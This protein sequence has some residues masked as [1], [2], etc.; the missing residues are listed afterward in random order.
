M[1][2]RHCFI[3]T[4]FLVLRCC[5]VSGLLSIKSMR[6]RIIYLNIFELSEQKQ[7]SNK[8]VYACVCVYGG[9]M[10]LHCGPFIYSTK[11][12]YNNIIWCFLLL[13]QKGRERELFHRTT[14]TS[15]STIWESKKINQID[16]KINP[17]RQRTQFKKKSA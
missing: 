3:K 9:F 4:I 16:K 1:Y 6:G 10:C 2:H 12:K 7:W 11:N 13:L 15:F 14:T 17:P 8:C 5:F